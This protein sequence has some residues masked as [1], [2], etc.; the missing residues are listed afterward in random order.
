MLWNDD[1]D[2]YVC[3]DTLVDSR[4]FSVDMIVPIRGVS[5]LFTEWGNCAF[6]C[7]LNFQASILSYSN[8]LW[9]IVPENQPFWAMKSILL[10]FEQ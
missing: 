3:M 1:I 9:K 8:I 5:T 10:A 4:I 2:V 7:N 6:Y